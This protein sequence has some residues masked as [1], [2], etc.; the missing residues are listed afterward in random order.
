MI[1]QYKYAILFIVKYLALYLILNTVYAFYIDYY[2]PQPDSLTISIAY[3]VAKLLQWIGEPAVVEI[4]NG[5]AKVPIM[6][7]GNV[8]V[9]V[10][11]GCN[12]VNVIIVY[13]SFLFAFSGPKKLLAKFLIVGIVL[14]YLINLFRVGALYLVALHNPDKL[15][16]FHKFFF[17]AIIYGFVFI[18]WFL[19]GNA[20]KRWNSQ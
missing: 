16:F 3:K 8:V 19:W 18:L 17:T 11:E 9:E 14:I 2:N 6:R 13:L 20:V 7:E 12:G 4:K 15:Y 1:A 5:Y 10:F